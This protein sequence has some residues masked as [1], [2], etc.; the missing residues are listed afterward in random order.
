M[1]NMASKKIFPLE[2][3]GRE[4][5]IV[6]STN[7]SHIGLRGKVVDETKNTIKIEQQGKI[8]TLLKNNIKF[9]MDKIVIDGKSIMKRS[10]DR[11]KGR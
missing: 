7:K 6:D 3:I 1:E 5:T 2:I 10:E 4:I 11:I 9:K 8:K